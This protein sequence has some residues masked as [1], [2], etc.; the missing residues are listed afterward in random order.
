MHVRTVLSAATLAAGGA[1]HEAWDGVQHAFIQ[2]WRRLGN[3]NGPAVSDWAAWLRR[4][5]VRRVVLDRQRMSRTETLS[6]TDF[7]L[8][9]SPLDTQVVLKEEYR[10]VLE[11]IARMPLRRRQALALHLIAGYSVAETAR[12]MG[13]EEATVRSSVRQARKVFSERK[14]DGGDS[15]D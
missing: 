3:P 1:H 10:R 9:A 8:D 7:V 4:T 15:S 14:P 11:I 6:D 5:A 2:A 13:V 12:V